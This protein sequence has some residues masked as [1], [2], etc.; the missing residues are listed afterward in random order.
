MKSKHCIS[1]SKKKFELSQIM[2]KKQLTQITGAA[3]P[4][5]VNPPTEKTILNVSIYYDGIWESVSGDFFPKVFI[6]GAPVDRDDR[7]YYPEK[8]LPK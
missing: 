6:G 3:G 1:M 2:N 8:F 7:W 5:P 4:V